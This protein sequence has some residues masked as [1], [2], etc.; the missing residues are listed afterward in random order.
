MWGNSFGPA[1]TPPTTRGSSTKPQ[2][3]TLFILTPGVSTGLSSSW[4]TASE[5]F[6]HPI[7]THTHIYLSSDCRSVD[8]LVHWFILPLFNTKFQLHRSNGRIMKLLWVTPRLYE[9][10]DNIGLNGRNTDEW[11]TWKD[12]E[13]SD[14]G[15]IK[16]LHRNLPGRT[17]KNHEN[18]R[19]S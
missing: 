10:L 16:E 6:S 5:Y 9:Y 19:W 15:L 18:P 1:L 4:F 17:E 8:S 11:W 3:D 2:V 12:L 13:E 7:N 14:S